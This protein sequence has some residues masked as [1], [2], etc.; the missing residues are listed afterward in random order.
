MDRRG[1]W[2]ISL[3]NS[4]QEPKV[5]RRTVFVGAML[6]DLLDSLSTPVR[7]GPAPECSQVNRRVRSLDEALEGPSF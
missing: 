6:V 2:A 7:W 1:Q 3:N 5:T 4:N